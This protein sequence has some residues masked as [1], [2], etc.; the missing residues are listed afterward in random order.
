MRVSVLIQRDILPRLT[1]I[2][3][4]ERVENYGLQQSMRIWLNLTMAALDVS[5]SDVA[6]HC[7]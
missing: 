3:D 5:T 2:P 6:A 4:V 7:E 1:A